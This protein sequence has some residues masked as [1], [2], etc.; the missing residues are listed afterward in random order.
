M[1]FLV[2]STRFFSREEHED[3][4]EGEQKNGNQKNRR[5][6]FLISVLHFEIFVPLRGLRGLFFFL[7]SGL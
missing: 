5:A 6:I 2:F 7:G 4:E 3:R 1:K